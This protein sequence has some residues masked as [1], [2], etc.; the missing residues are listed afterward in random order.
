MTPSCGNGRLSVSSFI[1]FFQR[2]IK[3]YKKKRENYDV[4]RFFVRPFPA[5]FE[6]MSDFLLMAVLS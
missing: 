6:N 1:A 5:S 2:N 3:K 4:L